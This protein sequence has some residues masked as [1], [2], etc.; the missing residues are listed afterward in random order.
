MIE[1]ECLLLWLQVRNAAEELL[2][3]IYPEAAESN[4][5][6]GLIRSRERFPDLA[7]CRDAEAACQE[8]LTG[9]LP[10][11][12]KCL[13]VPR[14]E[15]KSLLNQGDFL[16]EVDAARKDVPKASTPPFW[17]RSS[18]SLPLTWS[19]VTNSSG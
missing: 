14:L 4:D 12:A 17:P 19:I 13:A 8:H 9:L 16:I 2:S 1:P 18:H 3:C 11:L 6:V 15:Y 7:E 5:K 10:K